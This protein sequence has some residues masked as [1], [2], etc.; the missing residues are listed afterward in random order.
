MR[1]LRNLG[2]LLA[3]LTFTACAKE[4]Q[5]VAIDLGLLPSTCGADGARMS[6]SWDGSEFCATAQLQ[7]IGDGSSLLITGIDL[8]G[9][10][11]VLQLDTL[12]LGTHAIT[13]STNSILYVEP[14]GSHVVGPNAQGSLSITLHDTVAHRLNAAFS[15]PLVNPMSG[16]TRQLEGAVEVTYTEGN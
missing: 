14:T 7:A 3:I 4:A 12:S 6:A 5:E 15:V 2:L 10:S 8:T 9:S 1:T 13:E 16:I 11:L